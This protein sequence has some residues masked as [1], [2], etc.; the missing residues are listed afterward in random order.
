MTGMTTPT[1]RT[2]EAARAST[3]T[4]RT[5][6]PT[7]HQVARRARVSTA[8]VSRVISGAKRVSPELAERVWRAVEDLDYRPNKVARNLRVRATSTVGVVIPDVENPFFTSVVRGI[9]AGLQERRFTLLLAN[10][11]G[12]PE[13]ERLSL[14]TLCAEEVAGLLVVP[15]NADARPYQRVA[16]Q[17]VP[18]VAV[19]RSP[20]GLD[21]DLVRVTN[22]EGAHDAVSHLAQLGWQPIALV[23]G[24]PETNVAVER[25]RG[26]RRALDEAG[27]PHDAACI[28]R[29]DFK[30]EGGRRAMTALLQ[31]P[32]RPRA[33][34]VANNLMAMGALQAIGDAGLRV[35]QDIALVL[36]DDIPW[37]ACMNPP[38]TAV[39]QP[40]YDLGLS[41]ARLLLDRLVEPHRPIRHVVLRTTLIVRSSCGVALG[42]PPWT[43]QNDTRPPDRPEE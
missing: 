26:Y 29:A 19:D 41:A 24:P 23:G 21:V 42:R 10:S 13:R 18:V 37:A 28:Q 11:D 27:V 39:A 17:G 30:E 3:S 8:T 35:P 34:F 14:E 32:V 2:P 38:L 20:I 15:C 6:A 12:D 36:F 4:W 5:A 43:G 22:E 31:T 16:Q 25:E 7:I 33:V 9:E 40:T 1:R